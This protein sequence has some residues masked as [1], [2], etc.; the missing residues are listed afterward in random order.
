MGKSVQELIQYFSKFAKPQD[1]SPEQIQRGKAI[2]REPG[3]VEK[4]QSYLEQRY[5]LGPS[6]AAERSPPSILDTTSMAPRGYQPQRRAVGSPNVKRLLDNT[7]MAPRGYQPQRRA[8]GAPNARRLITDSIPYARPVPPPSVPQNPSEYMNPY[9]GIAPNAYVPS[10][11]RQQGQMSAIAN[12]SPI[13]PRRNNG[14][15]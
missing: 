8:L 7:S 14:A 1:F 5:G 11:M 10:W 13:I 2:A 12:R 15:V 3:G 9:D 4:I 6:P